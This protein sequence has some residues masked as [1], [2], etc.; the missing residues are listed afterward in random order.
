MSAYECLPALTSAYQCAYQ[1]T[2]VFL[3]AY[4]CLLMLIGAYQCAYQCYQCAY[5]CYQC[6]PVLIN[7]LIEAYHCLCIKLASVY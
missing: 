3:N 1:G 7:K 2:L 4:Q 5:Q 6:L